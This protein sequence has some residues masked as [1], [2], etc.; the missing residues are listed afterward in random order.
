LAAG[1]ARASIG[2]FVHRGGSYT[3]VGSTNPLVA[4][5]TLESSGAEALSGNPG[6]TELQLLR[7]DGSLLDA[8]T[9]TVVPTAKL[10]Y[11]V[12]WPGSAPLVLEGATEVWHVTTLDA[13][14][15]VTVGSGSV[16]F[17]TTGTLSQSSELP[18]G[19]DEFG[20]SGHA[21]GG[22]VIATAP[23]ATATLDVQVVPTSSL[24]SLSGKVLANST[25]TNGVVH[26]NVEVTASSGSGPVYGA[27]CK[28]LMPDPSV[29]LT[30]N[31]ANPLEKDPVDAAQ[32]TLGKT[33]SFLATCTIGSL[34]T[35]VQLSR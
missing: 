12:G 25:D 20:F 4:T 15:R 19:G 18:F 21:G 32:F 5:F 9:V 1:G 31:S 16:H 30:S 7:A 26:A 35:T 33:G 17:S 14:G 8:A 23:N 6:S 22:Q 24:T 34:S 29:T 28:W 3:S 13:N 2:V 11:Q 10:D 27:V